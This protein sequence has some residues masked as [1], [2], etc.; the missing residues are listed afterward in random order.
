MAFESY[1][2]RDRQTESTKIKNHAASR[3]VSNDNSVRNCMMISYD[4]VRVHKKHTSR[5]ALMRR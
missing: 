2:L 1:H 3:V 4:Q 5:K